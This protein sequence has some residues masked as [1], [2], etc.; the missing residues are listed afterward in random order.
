MSE[1]WLY[2]LR[3]GQTLAGFS[4]YPLFGDQLRGSTFVNRS[5]ARGVAGRADIGTALL[6][7][8][9]AFASDPAGTLPDD[10]VVLA[11]FAKYGTDLDAWA[12][13]R[14]G[15]L[16]GWSPCLVETE[17]GDTV[18]ALG[19]RVIAREVVKMLTRKIGHDQN[20]EA[21]RRAQRRARVKKALAAMPAVRPEWVEDSALH[22]R[23]ADLLDAGGV[24]INA[25]TVRGALREHL[26][27][28]AE[29]RKAIKPVPG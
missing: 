28:N 19:H 15:A 6:L 20:R 21:A 29:F 26:G 17:D 12:A 2:P 5:V 18:A 3:K 24:Y 1:L 10:D 13:A 7:W 22:D 27:V 25:D 9:E 4:W 16:Y 8:T 11:Q 23:I 14:T